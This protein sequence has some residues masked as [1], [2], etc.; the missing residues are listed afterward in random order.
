MESGAAKILP[1]A[2]EEIETARRELYEKLEKA[3]KE[4]MLKKRGANEVF[5][6]KRKMLEELLSAI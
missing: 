1:P 5:A 4:P 2:P 6:E 3:E